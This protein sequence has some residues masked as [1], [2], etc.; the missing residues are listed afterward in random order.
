MLTA[1]FLSSPPFLP[2]LPIFFMGVT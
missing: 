1:V 2:S